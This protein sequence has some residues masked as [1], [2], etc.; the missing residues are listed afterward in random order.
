MLR[1]FGVELSDA[2][3][4]SVWDSTAELRYMVLPQRP[5][6]TELFD[7]TKLATLISRDALIGVA[8]I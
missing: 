1:G 6:E 2:V 7:E 3:N 4:I 5:A 8:L